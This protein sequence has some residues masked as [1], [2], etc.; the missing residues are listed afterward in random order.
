MK[1][2]IEGSSVTRKTP[3]RGRKGAVRNNQLQPE[4]GRQKIE[5]FDQK[6]AVKQ[7]AEEGIKDGDY[8]YSVGWQGVYWKGGLILDLNEEWDKAGRESVFGPDEDW[9][10][11]SLASSC[12]VKCRKVSGTTYFSKG[13]LNE[14]GL[15]IKE[16]PDVN[17]VYVN[18][19]LTS[20]Q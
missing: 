14:L 9:R 13:V 20:M 8:V 17:V 19:T 10:N 11:E 3:S 12:I 2:D 18:A 5:L 7:K 1:D 4:G 6:I 15:F 16:K